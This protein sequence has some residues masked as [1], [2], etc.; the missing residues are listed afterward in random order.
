[1]DTA[2]LACINLIVDLFTV[3]RPGPGH[4]AEMQKRHD[5]FRAYTARQQQANG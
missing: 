5:R 3:D 4:E 1:M 2:H